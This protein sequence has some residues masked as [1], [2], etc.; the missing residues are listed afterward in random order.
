MPTDLERI[1]LVPGRPDPS[2]ADAILAFLGRSGELN[3]EAAQRR[4]DETVAIALDDGEIAGVASVRA[5][6]I[7]LVGDCRFWVYRSVL[8]EDSD[9]LWSRL[10]NEAFESLAEEFEESGTGPLGL[11]VLV[12]DP[13]VVERRPEAIWPADELLFAGWLE[14]GRQLRLRYFWGAAIAPGLPNS[15]SLDATA[16]DEYPLEDGYRI[17]PMGETVTADDVL[18]FWAAEGAVPD[19][20]EARRRVHEVKLVAIERDAGLAGISTLYLRRN[21]QLGMDLWH[22]RTFVGQAHRHSNLA[23]QLIFRNRALMDERYTSGEDTQAEGMIF[24]LENPGMKQY[25]NKALW[26]PAN[27]TFIGESEIGAHVRVHYFPGARVPLR[28][29]ST[30]A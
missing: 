12:D 11:C 7:S 23:A 27:F 9:A 22:Y 26:L 20:D 6:S 10:F 29:T 16:R 14:D 4:L 2:R 25:F 15:P 19:E 17:E 8:A 30:A 24:E 18:R 1:T 5:A 3:D 21:P 13:A 28:A